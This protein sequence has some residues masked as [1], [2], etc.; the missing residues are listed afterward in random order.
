MPQQHKKQ[1]SVC[2]LRLDGITLVLRQIAG[3]CGATTA[4]EAAL[5]VG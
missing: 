2:I 1:L 4:P 3:A 5:V